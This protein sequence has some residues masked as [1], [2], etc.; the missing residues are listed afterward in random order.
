[1]EKLIKSAQFVGQVMGL[2]IGNKFTVPA[3]K[4]LERYPYFTFDA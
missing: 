1:M 4:T 3:T 2:V